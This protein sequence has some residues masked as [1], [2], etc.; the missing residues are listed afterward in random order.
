MPVWAGVRGTISY[1]ECPPLFKSLFMNVKT[2]AR[3]AQVRLTP[4]GKP[5]GYCKFLEQDARTT[6]LLSTAR[7]GISNPSAPGKGGRIWASINAK[8]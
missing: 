7:D 6:M 8:L 5:Q 1:M 4:K 3:G 2:G